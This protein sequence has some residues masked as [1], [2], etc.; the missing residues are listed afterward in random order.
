MWFRRLFRR[1]PKPP[2]LDLS[3]LDRLEE[4]IARVIAL[5]PEARAGRRTVEPPSDASHPATNEPEPDDLEPD[6]PEPGEPEPGASAHL[7]LLPGY[8]LVE[9]NG[10]VPERGARIE[11]DD[12]AYVVLRHGPSPLPDD[13]RRCAFLERT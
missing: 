13:R 6:E 1:R 11:H 7:L 10:P 5:V 9:L 4:A 3:A 12:R 2:P 8:E